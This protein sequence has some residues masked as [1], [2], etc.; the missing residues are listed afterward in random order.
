MYYIKEECTIFVFKIILNAKFSDLINNGL[1]VGALPPL[2]LPAPVTGSL[3]AP[4]Y[5]K[6]RSEDTPCDKRYDKRKYCNLE[7]EAE[8]YALATP[9]HPSRDNNRLWGAESYPVHTP[10][11]GRPTTADPLLEATGRPTVSLPRAVLVHF[12][13]RGLDDIVK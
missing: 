4:Y 9:A 1:I 2:P 6:S 7:S 8:A 10:P 5:S 11:A 13:S 12:E 3:A